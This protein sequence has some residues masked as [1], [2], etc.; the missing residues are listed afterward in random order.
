MVPRTHG[1]GHTGHTAE[2]E[3]RGCGGGSARRACAMGFRQRHAGRDVA[4][5]N[6]D[7]RTAQGRAR[8]RQPGAQGDGEDAHGRHGRDG[9][10]PTEAQEHRKALARHEGKV[11][12]EVPQC[13]YAVG[14][15]RRS[16]QCGQ[17]HAH[18]RDERPQRG[19]TDQQSSRGTP[20]RRHEGTVG[21]SNR[22]QA[23]RVL[24]GYAG[25]HD[26]Q[27][28]RRG[29]RTQ[30]GVHWSHQG[31]DRWGRKDCGIPARNALQAQLGASQ[32]AKS[33]H[34][35]FQ[36]KTEQEV[37][38]SRDGCRNGK[39]SQRVDGCAGRRYDEP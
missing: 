4:T 12:R 25:H 16:A 13:P 27:G 32:T 18:Q 39:Q 23:H 5:Q 3:G 31:L 7:R 8:R 19:R 38:I 36:D 28:G 10:E 6:E 37:P 14:H 26:A 22:H 29:N 21:V 20:S 15:G 35:S 17:V 34:G 2:T 9:Y 11:G 1:Q 33:D 24:A 30:A